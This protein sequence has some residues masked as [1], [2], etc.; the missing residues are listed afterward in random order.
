MKEL[1]DLLEE[2]IGG[3]LEETHSLRLE[4][5][6][7]RQELATGTSSLTEENHALRDALAQ[8]QTVRET[9]THRIDALLL[10]LKERLPE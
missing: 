4:N 5:D 6:R 3:L 1:L 9:A 2:R 8:E 10:R 7:L